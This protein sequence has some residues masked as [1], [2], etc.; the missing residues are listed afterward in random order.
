VKQYGVQP[1]LFDAYNEKAVQHNIA[2]N[3]IS[4]VF[5]LIDAGKAD[6]QKH[7]IKAL[8]ELK[9]KTG[10]DVHFLHVRHEWYHLRDEILMTSKRRL[11]QRFSVRMLGRLRIVSF[12]IMRAVSMIYKRHRKLRILGCSL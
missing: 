1:L 12:A 10:L 2:E 6:S 7:F 11:E 8:A 9:N 4:V 3:E 5:H